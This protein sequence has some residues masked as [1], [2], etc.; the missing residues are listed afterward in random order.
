MSLAQ[1]LGSPRPC[2][3]DKTWLLRRR[4]LKHRGHQGTATKPGA[5][6]GLN[7]RWLK[8][9]QALRA[10]PRESR[11]DKTCRNKVGMCCRR[12][13]LQ[14][15]YTAMDRHARRL[16]DALQAF[17]VMFL[18]CEARLDRAYSY[19]H[20]CCRR[21]WLQWYYTAMDRHARS[22]WDTLQ[23]FLVMFLQC[24]ARLDRTYSYG[25]TEVICYIR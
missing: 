25:H 19:G 16:W 9:M 24:E 3:S 22:L 20:T 17:L 11:V 1:Q 8:T 2:E 5:G 18:Q 12:L 7:Q 4:W 14:W 6:S 15:Y 23:A 10:M 21:L 13:L